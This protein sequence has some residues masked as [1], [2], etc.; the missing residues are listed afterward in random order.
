[1]V[2]DPRKPHPACA[3]RCAGP[4]LRPLEVEIV[5]EEQMWERC[6][7]KR[8]LARTDRLSAQGRRQPFSGYAEPRPSAGR[9]RSSSCVME[10][11]W[12]S[13][14]PEGASQYKVSGHGGQSAVGLPFSP[15]FSLGRSSSSSSK[16]GALRDR[17]LVKAAPTRTAPTFP[18]WRTL[19][20]RR[21]ELASSPFSSALV[22][23]SATRR[24]SRVIVQAR[25]PRLSETRERWS[26]GERVQQQEQEKGLEPQSELLCSLYTG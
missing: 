18:A 1:M 14:R 17:E 8:S 7:L 3:R 6:K 25:G 22:S 21:P 11:R 23:P 26:S 10:K 16:E 13:P 2:L 19:C 15:Y 20:W 12:Q 24:P 5:K 4:T 9:P